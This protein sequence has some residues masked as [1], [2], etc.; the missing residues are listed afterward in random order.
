MTSLVTG[1]A[2]FI[3]ARVAQA[4]LDRGERVVGV[5]SMTD[6]YSLDQKQRNLDELGRFG[7]F[8]HLR[9]D[10]V[11]LE[12]DALDDVDVVYHL[13]GQPGVRNSWRD[14]F[15]VYLSRNVLAT[16][17][18]LEL[19]AA[20]GVSR[21]VYSSSSSVYGN[22]DRYPVEETMR[23]KP[24]SPYGVTKLAG[25]HLCT[26]YAQN[27]G[28]PVVSL[29]YFTVY[30]PGQRPDM[31]TYRLFEAALTGAP[32]P[33]FGAGD[34]VRDFTYVGDVVNA[35]LLAAEADVEPGL[36]VNI[37]GGGECSM[38]ELIEL[39]QE[40][41][42]RPIELDRRDAER[43]DVHRTGASIELAHRRLG[44]SPNTGL[45]SGLERQ[46]DWHLH[47]Q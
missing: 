29:R 25:E 20:S 18:L 10:L 27:F 35:N 42:G 16:Q 23:P 41:S 44:W 15:D 33:L 19:S 40:V 8:E 17:R 30:G 28:L 9:V 36:V 37:A 5:D 45:R 14:E 34:Q 3:G 2:G 21:F 6:Y 22:A 1:C 11:D 46:H 7:R 13:A 38:I 12:R 4:R 39:V 43:G 31:A 47:R 24:F 26:L 32:F